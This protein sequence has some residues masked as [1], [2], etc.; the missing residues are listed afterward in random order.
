MVRI[1]VLSFYYT[2]DLS[3]GSFRTTALV[4]A[5]LKNKTSDVHIDVVTTLPNRY[6]TFSAD[7][8]EYEQS[9]GLDIYRIK[10]PSHQSGMW[11]QSKSFLKYIRYVNNLVTN[12]QYDL[13]YATS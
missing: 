11:D 10:L 3:A 7:A 5:L 2:P 4:Q 9:N 6:K 8:P 1:L 12:H 13:V